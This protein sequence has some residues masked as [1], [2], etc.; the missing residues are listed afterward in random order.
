MQLRGK[1]KTL[2]RYSNNNIST[3]FIIKNCKGS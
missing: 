3:I 2:R 1:K